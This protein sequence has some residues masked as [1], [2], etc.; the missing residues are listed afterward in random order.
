MATARIGVQVD[1]GFGDAVH[2]A[3]VKLQYPSLLGLPTP[4]LRAYPRE[5]VV[6]EKFHAMVA[7]GELN[8][9]RKDFYDLSVLAGGF[10]FDGARL[11]A[12]IRATFDRRATDLPIEQPIAMRREFA[13]LPGKDAQWRAFVRRSRLLDGVV[14][15]VD[16][17]GRLREFLWPIV[18]ALVV[19]AAPPTTW[20]PGGPW[21]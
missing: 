17:V 13:A 18:G 14:P 9:R 20:Q 15:L 21:R 12:S 7:L 11:G 4:R 6:A 2:P 5:A 19:G 16:V 3:P 8:S 1:V 10:R